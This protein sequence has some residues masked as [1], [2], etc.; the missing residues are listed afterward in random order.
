M[1]TDSDSFSEQKTN[2][3]LFNII[4]GVVLLLI[5]ILA[6]YILRHAP[7][8][9]GVPADPY[10]FLCFVPLPFAILGLAFLIHGIVSKNK[11]NMPK[12]ILI[13]GIVTLIV[14][15]FPKIY[16]PLLRIMMFIVWGERKIE[17]AYLIFGAPGALFMIIGLLWLL[18]A[19]K[20]INKHI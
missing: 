1:G 20:K 5:V 8:I 14:C 19:R 9:K 15:V 12:L 16:I 3:R 17:I 6:I 7:C 11:A 13:S 4:V 18:T 10:S 2:W